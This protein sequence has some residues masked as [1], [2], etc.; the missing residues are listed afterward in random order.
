MHITVD[1]PNDLH[2]LARELAHRSNC[3]MDEVV[4]E[5]IRLGLRRSTNDLITS[6]RGMPQRSVGRQVTAEDVRTLDDL[7]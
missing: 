4:I 6:S 2:G 3:S 1:L 7:A 5:L